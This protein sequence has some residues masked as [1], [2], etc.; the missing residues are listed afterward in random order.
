MLPTPLVSVSWLS[1]HLHDPDL[2]I[3]DCR[4]DLMDP[5]AGVRAFHEGH[6]PGAAYVHLELDLSGPKRPGGAGGRHPLPEPAVLAAP[7]G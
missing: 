1:E 4:F 6:V 3:L 2:R 5:G 7:T